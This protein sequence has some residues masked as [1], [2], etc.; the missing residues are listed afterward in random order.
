MMKLEVGSW[1]GLDDDFR[2]VGGRAHK[3][4]T[5]KLYLNKVLEVLD[6]QEEV[7]GLWISMGMERIL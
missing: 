5:P 6:Y 3:A 1:L 2:K 4:I 7:R